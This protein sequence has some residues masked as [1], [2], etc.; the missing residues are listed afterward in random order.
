MEIDTSKAPFE[1]QPSLAMLEELCS[2]G[3]NIKAIRKGY[4][5]CKQQMLSKLGTCPTILPGDFQIPRSYP[6]TAH[7]PFSPTVAQ[8][9]IFLHGNACSQLISIPVTVTEKMDGGNCCI[10]RYPGGC[11]VE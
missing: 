2:Q 8:D 11:P 1:M 5:V 7:L 3:D 10:F 9:D 6:R 4:S